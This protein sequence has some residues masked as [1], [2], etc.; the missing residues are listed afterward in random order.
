MNGPDI[1]SG[2]GELGTS[3]GPTA[4]WGLI[5]S[6]IINPATG[7]PY[8]AIAPVCIGQ[9]LIYQQASGTAICL[10][11][12]DRVDFP[13]DGTLLNDAAGFKFAVKLPTAPDGWLSSVCFHRFDKGL[14]IVASTSSVQVTAANDK[15]LYC[16]NYYAYRSG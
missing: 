9:Y 10:Q 15:T 16:V 2:G 12:F 1:L 14:V 8:D 3:N 7:Q 4:L 5:P 13:G 6:K 11:V